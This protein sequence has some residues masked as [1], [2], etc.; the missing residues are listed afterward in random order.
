MVNFFIK[1]YYI[2]C[3]TGSWNSLLNLEVLN[4]NLI[5]KEEELLR[6]RMRIS[7]FGIVNYQFHEK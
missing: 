7:S 4:T 6:E 3:K 2:K 5:S 1:I